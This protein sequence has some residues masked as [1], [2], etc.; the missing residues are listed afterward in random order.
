MAGLV[1]IHQDLL[2]CLLQLRADEQAEWLGSLKLKTYAGSRC[3]VMHLRKQVAYLLA[4]DIVTLFIHLIAVIRNTK[5]SGH[6]IHSVT[7]GTWTEIVPGPYRVTQHG[8]NLSDNQL[9]CVTFVLIAL[10]G[11]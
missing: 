6:K 4:D 2:L 9:A 7:L 10:N 11:L 8:S 1:C 3:C 5:Q